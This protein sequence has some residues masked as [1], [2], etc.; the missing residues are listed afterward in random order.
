M[1]PFDL[2]AIPG[3]RNSV[4]AP[5]QAPVPSRIPW[6]GALPIGPT[7]TGMPV[8]TVDLFQQAGPPAGLLEEGPPDLSMYPEGGMSYPATRPGPSFESFVGEP[9]PQM[10]YAPPAPMPGL[11]TDTPA[12]PVAKEMSTA[13]KFKKLGGMVSE[14]A[15]P[16]PF[17][18]II[19]G[20]Q[21]GGGGRGFDVTPFLRRGVRAGKR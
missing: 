16:T 3:L 9:E 18:P 8:A 11:L 7:V 2:F 12:S 5:Q 19:S 13:E 6:A 1:S 21:A 20:P 4:F 15:K 17:S 14:G 10:S